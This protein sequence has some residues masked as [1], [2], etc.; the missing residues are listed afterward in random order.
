MTSQQPNLGMDLPVKE[1][2]LL[3]ITR[4]AYEIGAARHKPRSWQ[5][6]MQENVANVAEHV[7]R[8]TFLSMLLARMEGADA[9]KAAVISLVHDCDEIRAMDLT[10]YQKPYMQINSEKAVHDT[11]AGTPLEE[12]CLPLFKEYKAKETLESKCVK[13]ADIIDAILELMEIA[14][15]GSKYLEKIQDEIMGIR[16]GSLRTKSGE[17]L[18]DAITS[19]KVS[20]W[21]WFLKGPSTFK[22][23]TYGK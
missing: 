5:H 17:A 3:R 6:Q 20:P 1:D 2:T 22:D 11:F 16:K 10:P 18:F 14:D 13:D 15:R 19:G 4:F 23:G 7:Y 12:F 21:D 9:Y 8:V